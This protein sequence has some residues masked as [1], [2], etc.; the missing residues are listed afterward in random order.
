MRVNV[1]AADFTGFLTVSIKLNSKTTVKNQSKICVRRLKWNSGGFYCY[2]ENYYVCNKSIDREGRMEMKHSKRTKTKSNRFG[3][4]TKR[5]FLHRKWME[6]KVSFKFRFFFSIIYYFEIRIT[7]F[8][9]FFHQIFR[10]VYIF[11]LSTKFSFQFRFEN[12]FLCIS[13][14][15]YIFPFEFRFFF[16]RSKFHRVSFKKFNKNA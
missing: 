15:Q 16:R 11:F 2:F 8:F 14:K 3:K 5:T 9:D 10:L 12:M 13:N 7:I 4:P 6:I 1:N